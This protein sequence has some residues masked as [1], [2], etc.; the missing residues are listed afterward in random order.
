L[1][2]VQTA[3][4]IG[5]STNRWFGYYIRNYREGKGMTARNKAFTLTML[6][7]SIGLTAIFAVSALWLR[8]LLL[9]IASGVTFHLAESTPI[10][11][12][13]NNLIKGTNY[14]SFT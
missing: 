10:N 5:C 4:C 11:Q 14:G 8:L 13:E 1:P 12:K 2:A 9:G 6:W 7:L 3:S